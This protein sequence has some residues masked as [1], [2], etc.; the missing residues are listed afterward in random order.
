MIGYLQYGDNMSKEKG[1]AMDDGN[2]YAITTGTFLQLLVDTGNDPAIIFRV[3]E[4][5]R[6]DEK[7]FTRR[8]E[9]VSVPNGAV[10]D[11]INGMDVKAT[12][13][14]LNKFIEEGL[15]T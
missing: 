1:T 15:I 2:W 14:V 9:I 12:S 8:L 6:V 10:V 13:N 5:T 3:L 7:S 4:D 11:T